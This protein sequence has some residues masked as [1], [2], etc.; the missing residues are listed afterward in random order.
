[1]PYSKTRVIGKLEKGCKV[2]YYYDYWNGSAYV[3]K[4]KEGFFV[5]FTRSGRLKLRFW[6]NEH[7][8]YMQ[9]DEDSENYLIVKK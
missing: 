1:M 4:K 6:G 9:I 8:T 5:D 2:V 3:R 7:F